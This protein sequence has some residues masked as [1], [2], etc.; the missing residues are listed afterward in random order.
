[1]SKMSRQDFILIATV[2]ADASPANATERSFLSALVV[3]FANKLQ[4]T[5]PAFN[6]ALFMQAATGQVSVTARKAKALPAGDLHGSSSWERGEPQPRT[7][8]SDLVEDR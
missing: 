3:D 8:A 2:L 4:G 7:L 5:N 6:R 1:M